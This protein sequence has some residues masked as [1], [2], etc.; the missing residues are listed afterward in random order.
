MLTI[1]LLVG[2]AFSPYDLLWPISKRADAGMPDIEAKV[3][4]EIQKNHLSMSSGGYLL[5]CSLSRTLADVSY[6]FNS[7]HSP[8]LSSSTDDTLE[9]LRSYAA[10]LAAT[11]P[12]KSRADN[13]DVNSSIQNCDTENRDSPGAGC[14]VRDGK[15]KTSAEREEIWR[16]EREREAADE[17]GLT[18]C[19]E[20]V[21]LLTRNQKKGELTFF[22]LICMIW[23]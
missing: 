5:F 17:G 4:E 15:Q 13:A 22:T 10:S 7:V 21:E 2:R 9:S 3:V 1:V 18:G 11:L 19:R 8:N 12:G 16:I 14:S 23:Y 6:P 20:A